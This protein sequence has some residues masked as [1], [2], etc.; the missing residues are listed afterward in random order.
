MTSPGGA[1]WSTSETGKRSGNFVNFWLKASAAETSV[2]YR[3]QG[4]WEKWFEAFPKDEQ[5]RRGQRHM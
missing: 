2:P 5:F 4:V 3:N 1:N